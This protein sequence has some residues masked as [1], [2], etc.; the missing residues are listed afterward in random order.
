MSPTLR[1]APRRFRNTPLRVVQVNSKRADGR[2]DSYWTVTPLKNEEGKRFRPHFPTRA[3][4][5]AERGRRERERKLVGLEGSQMSTA[6]RMEAV[7]AQRILAPLRTSL[8]EAAKHYVAHMEK[9]A[10]ASASKTMTEAKDEYLAKLEKAGT[11]NKDRKLA[12]VS[13]KNIRCRMNIIC[14][15]LEGNKEVPILGGFKLPSVSHVEIN[16]FLE[17]LPMRSQTVAHYRAQIHHF[18]EFARKKGWVDANPVKQLG[19][20]ERVKSGEGVRILS[21]EQAEELL[22]AAVN[23]PQ[24]GV[25]VPRLALGLFLGLRP[26]E[27]ENLLWENVDFATGFV[28]VAK[29]SGK[30]KQ[31]RWVPINQTAKAWLLKYRRAKGP[32][33]YL[34]RNLIRRSWDRLRKECGWAFSSFPTKENEFEHDVLRHSFG[35]YMLALTQNREKTVEIMGTSLATF[36]KHYLVTMPSSWA[37]KYWAILPEDYHNISPTRL[38]KLKK[39]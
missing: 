31:E 38:K 17:N 13:L 14:N 24:A 27:A 5:E 29:M 37:E 2:V 32:V 26:G 35:S 4:A 16:E 7:Q 1:P 19:R 3:E 25:L 39:D 15:G 11:Q 34:D 22:E 18:F 20:S 30:K 23:S 36:A 9:S 8:V 21:I 12:E 10:K 33:F 6:L 28:K